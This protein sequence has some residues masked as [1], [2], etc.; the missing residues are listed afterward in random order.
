MKGY[1][2]VRSGLLKGSFLSISYGGIKLEYRLGVITNRPE[3]QGPLAVFDTLESALDFAKSM[4]SDPA[5]NSFLRI[6]LCEFSPSKDDKLWFNHYGEPV[7]NTRN[8]PQ[9]TLFA[10]SVS[11]IEEIRW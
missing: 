11:L 6:F 8:L 9:G 7:Y 1:K 3:G 4:G 10:D 5:D 2:T